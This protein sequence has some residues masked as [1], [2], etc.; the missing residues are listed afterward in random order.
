MFT[1]GG[2]TPGSGNFPGISSTQATNAESVYATLVGRVTSYNSTA[3]FAP[4]TK[5][6]GA[7][8]NSLNGTTG[9]IVDQVGQFEM[10]VYAAD[11]WRVKPN[12]TFNY[13]L[14]WEYQSAPWDKL[15]EYWM[16]QNSNDV[17]G[18]SGPGNLFH[19]GST[20]GNGNAAFINDAGR[21]WYNPYFKAFAPS[22]G[23]AYQPGWDNGM[24][25]HVFG[26]P[27]K[28]VLRAGFSIAYDREGLAAFSSIVQGNARFHR[29]PND[30]LLECDQHSQFHV[31]SGFNL[32]RTTIHHRYANSTRV[33]QRNPVNPTIGQ[34][35]NGMIQT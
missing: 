12:V 24:M 15:N 17:F 10:G 16:L 29:R 21:S 19:P 32:A 26:A 9:R 27:G 22:V 28:T 7:L 6:Y 23:L 3:A 30:V 8:S 34:G 20:A 25:R 33:Q 4:T 11:S 35:V 14:R 2:V 1:I 31:P 13:G 5:T 18:I